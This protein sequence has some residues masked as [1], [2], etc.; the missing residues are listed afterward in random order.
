[1]SIIQIGLPAKT[2]IIDAIALDA[3]IP[4]L[5]PF[6][7]DRNIRKIAW[8]ARLGYSE[9]RHRYKVRM[10]NVLDL[11]LVY[12]HERY[13]VSAQKCVPL[14]GKLTAIKEKKL[15]SPAAVE[16]ELKSTPPIG[17]AHLRTIRTEQGQMERQTV[18]GFPSRVRRS[19][20]DPSPNARCP[21][22]PPSRKICKH[23]P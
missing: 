19:A 7:S 3:Q 5:A 1:M 23:S 14:S 18:A 9:L 16:I 21:S 20:N 10:Q 12:L 22:C 17:V 15:L 13:D 4:M 6:L 8:D 11:Q 2:Y